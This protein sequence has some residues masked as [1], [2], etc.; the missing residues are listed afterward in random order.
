MPSPNDIKKRV[1]RDA[2]LRWIPLG[3]MRV[4]ALAQRELNESRVEHIAAAMDLEQ[5]GTPTVNERDGHFYVIDGQHRVEALRRWLGDDCEGQQIQCWSYVGLTEE[6]EAEKFL[7]LNDTLTVNAM[8]KF[9][10][11]AGENLIFERDGYSITI[12]REKVCIRRVVGTE[13]VEHPAVEAREAWT[14]EREVVEWDCEPVLAG[15]SA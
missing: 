11:G 8:A 14:E 9:K 7:K 15:A 5:I 13:T 4:S 3:K 6:E 1:E 12:A 10:V 2:R